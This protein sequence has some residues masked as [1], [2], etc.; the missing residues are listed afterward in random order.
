MVVSKS[1]VVFLMLMPM[2]SVVI[3][4]DLNSAND[5]LATGSGDS[6]ARICKCLST[7]GLGLL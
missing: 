7:H 2:F 5:L 6:Y 4:L 3:S 1:L